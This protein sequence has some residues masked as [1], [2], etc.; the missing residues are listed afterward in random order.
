MG[1]LGEK[2]VNFGTKVGNWGQNGE[3]WGKS[4]NS[5]VKCGSL[6]QNGLL[7]DKM[8]IL[9]LKWGNWD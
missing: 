5:G 1:N 9:E 7:G 8:V 6:G 2:N 3:F 4:A